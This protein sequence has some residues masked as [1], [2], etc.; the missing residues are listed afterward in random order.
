MRIRR[1]RVK[2]IAILDENSS[3][4]GVERRILMENA[5]AE[6]ARFIRSLLDE[7][8]GKSVVVFAGLGN[9]GGDAL[10]VARHLAIEGAKVRVVLLGEPSR[11]RTEEARRNWEAVERMSVTI[12]KFVVRETEDLID[13]KG[14]VLGADVIVDGIL[15]TGIRGELREPISSAVDL[16]NESRAITVSIDV[17]SGVDPDTGAVPSKFV[18]AD[19]TVTLHGPKPFI[20]ALQESL[21]GKVIV[22]SIG[23]PPEA[24]L[25]AGPGDLLECLY[26]M[27]RGKKM[28]VSSKVEGF[29]SGAKNFASLVGAEVSSSLHDAL[30]IRCDDVTVADDET[31]LTEQSRGAL[32]L[33]SDDPSMNIDSGIAAV[34]MDR[35]RRLKTLICSTGGCGYITDGSRVKF[36]WLEPQIGTDPYLLGVYFAGIAYFIAQGVEPIIAAAGSS[37]LVRSTL[38]RVGAGYERESFANALEENL[39]DHLG[40]IRKR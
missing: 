31:Y 10:V 18:C 36:N 17:P 6:V 11:I 14:L 25:V 27:S 22:R 15:G 13:L 2:D 8:A 30:V 4:L 32:V 33:V 34:V 37:Y 7:V 5:G 16:I 26:Y 9:N 3:Y 20:D 1:Y 28:I 29:E 24:E 19:Y 39:K 35:A 23:A 40:R 21:I 38:R 12:E